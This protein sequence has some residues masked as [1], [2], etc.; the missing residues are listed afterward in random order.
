LG[1]RAKVSFDRETI[2]VV[3]NVEGLKLAPGGS[4]SVVTA[5]KLLSTFFWY[6]ACLLALI[7]AIVLI[8]KERWRVIG[9]PALVLTVYSAIFPLLIVGQDRYHMPM[10]PTMAI[11]AAIAIESFYQRRLKNR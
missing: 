6:F 3:W 11:L 9:N 1:K 7:G 5:L 8:R 4:E 2:G 10:I